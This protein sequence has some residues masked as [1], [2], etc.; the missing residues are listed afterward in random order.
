MSKSTVD[1][2]ATL[3]AKQITLYSTFE[4]AA[5]TGDMDYFNKLLAG[6]IDGNKTN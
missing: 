1:K 3:K 4:N 2:L 5:S 6:L